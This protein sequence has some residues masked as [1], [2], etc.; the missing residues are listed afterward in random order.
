MARKYLDSDEYWTNKDVAEGFSIVGLSCNDPSRP[1]MPGDCIYTA[2]NI[3][4]FNTR[5]LRAEMARYP[6]EKKRYEYEIEDSEKAEALLRSLLPMD[7]KYPG[8]AVV[9]GLDKKKAKKAK[10]KV[11]KRKAPRVKE[12]KAKVLKRKAPKVKASR[13]SKNRTIVK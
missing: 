10:S 12:P 6:T 3:C 4:R 7:A 5:K 9:L 2:A 11:L 1:I 8:D 13:R